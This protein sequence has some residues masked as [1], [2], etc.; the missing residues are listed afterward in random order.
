MSS[1]YLDLNGLTI[2]DALIKQ[3]ISTATSNIAKT[4]VDNNFSTTQTINGSDDTPLNLKANHS[5]MSNI[6]LFNSSG[7]RLGNI[8]ANGY[9]PYWWAGGSGTS[10]QL[11]LQSELSSYVPTSRT[12]NGKALS[13]NV[14][15]NASDVSAL[16]VTT[17]YVKSVSASGNTLSF[18]TTGLP[19]TYTPSF[20]GGTQ[21]YKHTLTKS[22]YDINF[23]LITNTSTAITFDSI[24]EAYTCY[25]LIIGCMYYDDLEGI[26]SQAVATDKWY[27]APNHISFKYFQYFGRNNTT[28]LTAV[29]LPTDLTDTITAL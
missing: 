11:A 21:L 6:A 13:S 2:Y 14:M 5:T 1:K 25:G 22:G 23:I 4:N 3:T 7:T 19:V 20:S 9:V 27:H 12:I 8:G 24:E 10:G 17:S 28:T 29:Q 26:L 18:T 15:L 16:D